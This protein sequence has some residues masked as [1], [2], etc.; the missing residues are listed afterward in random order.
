MPIN[1]SV[2]G[3][4]RPNSVVQYTQELVQEYAKCSRDIFHFAENY[5]TIIE[6]KRGKHIVKLFD[7]Q[8]EMI[9]GFIDDRFKVILSARQ[10]GK[11][12]CSALYLLWFAMFQPDKTIGI[13][14]NK[15]SIAK[16]IISEIKT[17]YLEIPDWLKPGIEKWDQLELK[18]DNGSII[19]AG[20]TS[21][22]SFR[23][24]SLSVLFL[25]EFAFVPENVAE[26]FF[27]SAFP[28]IS[29]GGRMI[30]VSTPKGAAGKFYDIYSKAN[31]E[32]PFKSMK[33]TW[34]QH[35]DRDEKWK[36]TNLKILG[37]VKFAQEHECAGINTIVRIR[38]KKSGKIIELTLGELYES[39]Q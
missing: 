11:T 5:Y 34:K 10:M 38:D 7:Y 22:D 24:E 39:C 4:K 2:K 37:K 29:Q 15:E 16:S 26:D 21:E 23:G 1:Y 3:L 8:K 31:L 25:D 14:A 20:A 36:E 28:T 30:I 13:L 9:Q 17:A 32:N 33:I 18:F 12:T 19:M 27:T 6:E 35:P